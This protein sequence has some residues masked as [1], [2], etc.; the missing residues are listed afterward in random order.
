ME[1]N[2]LKQQDAIGYSGS[3]KISLLKNKRKLK[4]T[5]YRNNGGPSL[6]RFLAYTTAGL[7]GIA[8]GLRPRYV[9]LVRADSDNFMLAGNIEYKSSKVL[10]KSTPIYNVGTGNVA[11]TTVTFEFLIPYTQIIRGSSDPNFIVLYS[12]NQIDDKK[13]C[14]AYVPFDATILNNM[15][16]DYNLF[17]EWTLKFTN[18]TSSAQS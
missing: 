13:E 3:V 10:Y 16:E 12:N 1:S 18:V 6:F 15:N 5:K 17:V 7:Y 8:D 11:E 9:C 2:K 4:T 14:C